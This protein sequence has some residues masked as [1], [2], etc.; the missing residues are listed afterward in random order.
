MNKYVIM[1]SVWLYGGIFFYLYLYFSNR[2]ELEE[3]GWEAVHLCVLFFVCCFAG[4]PIFLS[5]F[6]NFEEKD[7][8]EFETEKDYHKKLISKLEELK[9]AIDILLIQFRK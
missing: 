2:K 8:E 3:A 9:E 5:E 4:I 1:L 6:F 7:E